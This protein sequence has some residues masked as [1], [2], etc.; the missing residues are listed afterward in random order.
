VVAARYPEA[1]SDRVDR[2]DLL[3]D[4]LDRGRVLL[5]NS[6]DVNNRIGI[7]LSREVEGNGPTKP[8]NHRRR[9]ERGAATRRPQRPRPRQV[10]IPAAPPVAGAAR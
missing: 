3:V 1:G 10:P 6:G 9:G 7:T 2:V 8:G 4:L 5:I